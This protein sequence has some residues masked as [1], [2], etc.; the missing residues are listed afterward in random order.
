MRH[1]LNF[2]GRFSIVS[3]VKDGGSVG[4]YTQPFDARTLP[5]SIIVFNL[6]MSLPPNTRKDGPLIPENQ[7]KVLVLTCVGVF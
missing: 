5:S 1:I 3:G 2:G 6:A 4:L 7:E